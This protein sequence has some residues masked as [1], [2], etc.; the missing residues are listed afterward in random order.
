MQK[1]PEETLANPGLRPRWWLHIVLLV[2]TFVTTTAFGIVL[3]TGLVEQPGADADS[4]E[5]L[6]RVVTSARGIGLA[7][8]YSLSVLAIL[9]AHEMGHY[10]VA[11]WYAIPVSPPYFLP[12][13]PPFAPALGEGCQQPCEQPLQSW[14]SQYIDKDFPPRPLE[15]L[16]RLAWV[17]PSTEPAH[18]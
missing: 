11:R 5:P 4:L 6:V 9:F 12:G 18:S 16:H 1:E 2:V 13:L 3:A 7:L 17:C 8:A 15:F 10:L 14:C